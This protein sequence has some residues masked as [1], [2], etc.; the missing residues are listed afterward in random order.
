MAV[1]AFLGLAPAMAWIPEVPLLAVAILLPIVAYGLAGHRAARR[2][3]RALAGLVAGC[4]AG[5]ISGAVGGAAYV[6]FGKSAL[7]VLV[8]VVLGALGGALVGGA[9]GW[10]GRPAP[11]APGP[12]AGLA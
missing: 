8:G 3:G 11:G 1:L 5:A 2:S 7:N 6:V 9:G 12:P 4:L 10:L